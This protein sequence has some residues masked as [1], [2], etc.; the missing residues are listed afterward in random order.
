MDEITELNITAIKLIEEKLEIPQHD[1][2][3]ESRRRYSY[4]LLTDNDGVSDELEIY[5][6]DT[7]PNVNVKTFTFLSK[8]ERL[9]SIFKLGSINKYQMDH[10]I[11]NLPTILNRMPNHKL[12]NK[13]ITLKDIDPQ[14][15]HDML[16]LITNIEINN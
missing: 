11:D 6:M 13:S 9:Y 12:V 8:G 10:I 5:I 14:D 16:N 1:G 7:Y 15:Y 4:Y 2:I 3:G